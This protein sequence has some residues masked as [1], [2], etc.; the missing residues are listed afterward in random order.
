MFYGED[1]PLFVDHINGDKADNRIR[2]L[3]VGTHPQNMCNRHA[4]PHNTSGEKGVHLRSDNGKWRA[5]LSVDR[6]RFNLGTFLKKDD[7]VMA[8]RKARAELHGEFAK[9]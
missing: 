7:A 3:R 8:V 4:P 1:P 2:N 5:Y 9:H 6:K